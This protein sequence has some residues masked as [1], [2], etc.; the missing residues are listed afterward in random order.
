[1][2]PIEKGQPWGEPGGLPD[3]GIVVATDAEARAVLEEARRR[4]RPFPP[5]GLA[6]GDLCRTL[7]GGGDVA[8]LRSPK[9]MRFHVDVGEALLDG[10]LHLFVA[11]LVAHTP[12]WGRVFVAMNAQRRR[13]W[14]LGPRAHPGDGLLDIYEAALGPGAR[15]AVRARLPHGVHMPHPGIDEQRVGAAQATFDRSA[16]VALDGVRTGRARTISVRVQ[17]AALTVV[18]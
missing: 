15:L 4:H 10:R 18:V 8:R 6:G 14:L 7:G 17:P 16:T 1:V 13:D 12:L 3:E 9:A 11:H 2:A 5:I